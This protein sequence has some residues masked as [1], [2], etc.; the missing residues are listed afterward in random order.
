MSALPLFWPSSS[1][2]FVFPDSF[3]SSTLEAEL[4]NWGYVERF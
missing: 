2:H 3:S 4:D 1:V